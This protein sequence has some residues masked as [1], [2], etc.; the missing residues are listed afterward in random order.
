MKTI[1]L[2]HAA[3]TPVD[4]RVV[5]AMVPFFSETFGNPSSFHQMGMAAKDAVTGARRSI[6][7]ILHAHEDEILFTSGGTESDNL[8]IV[9]TVRAYGLSG[10]P[11]M[12]TSAVEHHAVLEPLL[13]LKKSGEIDLTILPVDRHGMVSVREVVSAIGPATILVSIMYA[14]NEI[15]TIEPIAEVGR[16]ILRHRHAT[17]SVFPL[18]HT[19]ACQAAGVL[20]LDVEKLHT[21]LLTMNGSKIYG[22]KGIGTLF[23]RRGVRIEPMI[24]GG[25]QER[26]IRSGT[27]HVAGI[28]GLA[29]ALTLAQDEREQENARLLSL[30]DQLIKGLLRIPKTILNGHAI[31]RLPN[32]VNMSF[33]DV[34]GEAAVLYLDAEGIMASTGSACASASLEPSHV[35]RATGLSYEAAHGSIRFTLGRSTTPDDVSH[36]IQVM[37]RIVERLRKM[38]PVHLEMKHFV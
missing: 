11:H 20:S 12:V 8:A 30:R 15:G 5:E 25:G 26:G 32:N 10:R 18:F 29:H 24:R 14:N 19:D 34:E 4:P 13:Y 23:V 6:A 35:I 33:L 3:T 2:D 31:A 16:A 38:S 1:Y 37:P 21:D 7:R 27:E 22:P 28:V 9:G 17:A 36:V